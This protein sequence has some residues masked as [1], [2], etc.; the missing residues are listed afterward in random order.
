MSSRDLSRVGDSQLELSRSEESSSE[1][2]EEKKE[3]LN[4]AKS[5]RNSEEKDE[6]N[7]EEA[8][9]QEVEDEKMEVDNIDGNEDNGQVEEREVAENVEE[10]NTNDGF[11]IVN[12]AD[13]KSIKA[14]RWV[15]RTHVRHDGMKRVK[16]ER[17]VDEFINDP[18][19]FP[20]N[21]EHKD[22]LNLTDEEYIIYFRK[23]DLEQMPSDD[24][25]EERKIW[26]KEIGDTKRQWTLE[27]TRYLI[28]LYHKYTTR[29]SIIADQYN[30]KGLQP[31]SLYE[32]KTR[33][34]FVFDLMCF[35][36]DKRH[37]MSDYDPELEYATR[38]KREITFKITP[39]TQ[40][41]IA[42]L[43]KELMEIS[44][45]DLER[46]PRPPPVP[47][48][49]AAAAVQKS[50]TT[51]RSSSSVP[52]SRMPSVPKYGSRANLDQTID[53]KK[54]IEAASD[55]SFLRFFNSQSA[56]PHLRSQEYRLVSNVNPKKRANIENVIEGLGL[57]RRTVYNE[58]IAKYYTKLSTNINVI[59]EL[60]AVY[61]IASAE[62]QALHNEYCE[63][64]G[65]QI[66]LEIPSLPQSAEGKP[67][68]CSLCE[69][70]GQSSLNR[71]RI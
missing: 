43:E 23:L 36:R 70:P 37:L 17:E 48:A 33:F 10:E 40:N 69:A 64:S 22:I 65:T 21:P 5:Q 46:P 35:V 26:P 44:P 11:E 55:I 56:G 60:K 62:C 38:K 57:L 8:A 63:K 53:Y 42:T 15:K 52:P 6:E 45:A 7:N 3:E 1:D 19:P 58:R 50:V 49:P 71:K 47:D 54:K 61:S 18:A 9:E 67:S 13:Y 68:I 16:W 30:Y 34:F 28:S 12:E 39:K 27:E 2:E 4:P 41:R 59:S 31:R 25:M 66:K 14:K 29:W 32:I 51:G 20:R 24:I